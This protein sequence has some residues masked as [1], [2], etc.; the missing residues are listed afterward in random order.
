MLDLL[1]LILL[2]DFVVRPNVTCG[3]GRVS[4]EVD[5]F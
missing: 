5:F 2:N 3:Q 4:L 1:C